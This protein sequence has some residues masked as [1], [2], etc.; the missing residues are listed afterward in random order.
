MYFTNETD[1]PVAG[2]PK[3]IFSYYYWA[4]CMA[5]YLIFP[6]ITAHFHSENLQ[7]KH[8]K[9][10]HNGHNSCDWPMQCAYTQMDRYSENRNI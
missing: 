5:P 9:P 7:H 3:S 6:K 1:D 4:N 2:S 10:F 8:N